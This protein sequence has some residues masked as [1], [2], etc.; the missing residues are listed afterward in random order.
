MMITQHKR[1]LDI[2]AAFVIII[3]LSK[4]KD[5]EK[6]LTWPVLEN[7]NIALYP[8]LWHPNKIIQYGRN[9]DLV[10]E[11]IWFMLQFTSFPEFRHQ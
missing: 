11:N 5:I 7:Y 8:N 3:I 1:L 9:G 4:D 10:F 2:L 6:T